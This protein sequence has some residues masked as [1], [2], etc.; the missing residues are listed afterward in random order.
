[1]AMVKWSIAAK[2]A[3]FAALDVKD[4][5]TLYF[6]EET[7]EIYRGKKSYTESCVLYNSVGSSE[8][9]PTTGAKGKLY[10]DSQTFE[11]FIW[12]G[13]AYVQVAK[14][15]AQTVTDEQ[16]QAVSGHAVVEY[17]KQQLATTDTDLVKAV[18][19]DADGKQLKITTKGDA[20]TNVPLNKLA[21]ALEYNGGTGSITLKDKDGAQLSEINIPKDNFVK[22]GRYE[23]NSKEIVLVMQNSNEVRI[24]AASLVDIYTGGNSDNV[25][26]AVSENNE[27]TA[28]VKIDP[29]K[30]NLLTSS[31]AGLKVSVVADAS[32]MDKVNADH[33]G[34][35]LAADAT[36]NAKLTGVKVGGDTLAGKPNATTLATEA[37]VKAAITNIHTE[38]F[39]L[40]SDI[41]TALTPDGA[42]GTKVASEKA[43]V[44]ALTWGTVPAAVAP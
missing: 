10:V 27:I 35:L 11:S 38:N 30:G 16:T 1:M 7:G 8:A 5:N 28:T 26:V 20:T 15:L 34:E 2:A 25:A 22:E 6:V 18:T 23:A 14:A 17:V 40:K 21:T 33:D 9:K 37:A 43:V 39:V 29:A 36:G 41:A 31:T 19:W 32:K 13:T 12:N 44:D 42:S 3:D 24:P 4:T